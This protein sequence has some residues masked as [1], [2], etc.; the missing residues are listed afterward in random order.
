MTQENVEIVRRAFEL[1]VEGDLVGMAELFQPEIVVIP[2][3]GWPEGEP[4]EGIEGWVRQAER[5]R[6][7]WE[8]VAAEFDEIRAVGDERVFA[9]IR[10]VTRSEA[11]M[12]FDTPM[13]LAM[14]LRDGRIARAEYYWDA[15]EALAAV[16][17][18]E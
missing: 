15:E 13:A 8:E 1:W 7:A 12:A 10:Y 14:F 3:S 2:P 11:G 17:R 5:L 18:S 6:E 4:V 9:R 16:G